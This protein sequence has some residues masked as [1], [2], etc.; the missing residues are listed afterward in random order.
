METINYMQVIN[1]SRW[2]PTALLLQYLVKYYFSTFKITIIFY[3]FIFN[4]IYS[5]D[6]FA[7][8]L[9][10]ASVIEHETTLSWETMGWCKVIHTSQV[11]M[12]TIKGKDAWM[13]SDYIRIQTSPT[14]SYLLFYYY[15]CLYIPFS[16][17]FWR[18]SVLQYLAWCS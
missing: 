3:A 1:L 16:D 4:H 9:F 6:V 17:L 12:E 8:F 10:H 5:E 11:T 7:Y 15:L 13:C 2:K 18:S 14:Y